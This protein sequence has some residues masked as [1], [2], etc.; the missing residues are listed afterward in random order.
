MTTQRQLIISA[1]TKVG[2]ET[3]KKMT[4][5]FNEHVVQNGWETC[6]WAYG[7]DSERPWLLLEDHG[8]YGEEMCVGD[9]MM[10][11]FSI[12]P[13]TVAMVFRVTDTEV[14]A[15]IRAFDESKGSEVS[16]AEL[17]QLVKQEATGRAVA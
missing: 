13:A 11:V 9:E 17:F 5:A 3:A 7:Y 1:L 16:R 4:R 8:F 12:D 2:P 6:M 10:P 15:V 14:N